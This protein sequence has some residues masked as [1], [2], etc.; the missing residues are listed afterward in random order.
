MVL[1]RGA[2]GHKPASLGGT[3]FPA[4]NFNAD[5]DVAKIHDAMKGWGTDEEPL[6]DVLAYRSNAQRQ[7]IRAKYPNTYN[8]KV[9]EADMINRLRC[10]KL[11]FCA[12]KR[13]G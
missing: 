1:Q 2:L 9:R 6:I 3:V 4:K 13:Y 10:D 5:D 12:V 7:Q 11:F 8:N